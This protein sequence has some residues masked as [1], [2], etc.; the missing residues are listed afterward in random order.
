[1]TPQEVVELQL[2]AYNAKD[3]EKFALT[4]AEDVHV[5]MMPNLL[6]AVRGREA[7]RKHYSENVFTKTELRAEVVSRSIV[8]NKVTEHEVVHGLSEKPMEFVVVYEVVANLIQ[9]VWFY[10]PNATFKP[11]SAA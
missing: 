3:A 7:L 5:L 11:S 1:M 4:Y 2:E 8:G 6:L 9:A 10:W